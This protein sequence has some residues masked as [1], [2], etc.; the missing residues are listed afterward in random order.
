MNLASDSP[1][2]QL[3]LPSPLQGVTD[4]QWT[5]FVAIMMTEPTTAVGPSN[6]LGAFQFKPRR[7]VDLGILRGHLERTRSEKSNRVI[8]ATAEQEDRDRAEAFL[9][10]I[11]AQERAFTKSC[12]DYASKIASGEISKHPST[13]LSEALAILHR[14][15]PKGLSSRWVFPATQALADKAAGIF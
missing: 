1:L 8:W 2:P 10:S 13:S 7:L 3:T 12:V 9:K 14:S 5:R 4:D 15:G 6:E 11:R